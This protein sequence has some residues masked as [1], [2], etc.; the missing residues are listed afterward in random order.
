M[1]HRILKAVVHVPKQGQAHHLA[2]VNWCQEIIGVQ[3]VR[4]FGYD[5]GASKT[6][7]FHFY[8]EEDATAFIIR[9]GGKS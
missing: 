1:S 6:T 4:W 8:S 5:V 3:N 9:W 2:M 7:L